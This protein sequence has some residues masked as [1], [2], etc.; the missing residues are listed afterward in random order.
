MKKNLRKLASLFLCLTFAMS[1]PSPAFAVKANM[2]TIDPSIQNKMMRVL[3]SVY[4]DKESFGFGDVDFSSIQLGSEIPAYSVRNGELKNADARIIPVLYDNEIL[5]IFYIVKDYAG[6]TFVQLSGG[7]VDSISD[8]ANDSPIAIVYD[9]TGV[10]IFD[11]ERFHLI[12]LS[13]ECFI[14][15]AQAKTLVS[16]SKTSSSTDRVDLIAVADYNE[17]ETTSCITPTTSLDVL[18][19][20]ANT[21]QRATNTVTSRYLTVPIINQPRGTNVC[22]AICI[23]SIANYMWNGDWEYQDFVEMFNNGQT[24]GL[25]ISEAISNFNEHFGV[26]WGYAYT[27]KLDPE[28]ILDYLH[29]NYPLY[30]SFESS[31]GS[32]AVVIR[33]V[34]VPLNTFSV[35]NPNP[36]ATLYGYDAGT[37]S[38]NNTLSFYSENS[39]RTYTMK[40]YGAPINP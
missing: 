14:E 32:H 4:E 38:S 10:H 21:P 28:V 33:G 2:E 29:A 5:S 36:N 13:E 1:L 26:E 9:D 6:E 23:T 31:E 17:I 8:Y 30:G 19:F 24:S 35:M 27:S 39:E 20:L 22:W 34:N 40:A 12:G 7:L 3:A 37:I 11:K 16:N 18:S 15:E 25:S